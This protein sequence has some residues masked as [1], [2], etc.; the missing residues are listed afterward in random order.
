MLAFYNGNYDSG[1]IAY[2]KEANPWFT[3]LHVSAWTDNAN[4]WS[5]YHNTFLGSGSFR[6]NTW[7]PEAAILDIENRTHPSTV[8]LPAVINSSVSEWPR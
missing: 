3:Q 5:W 8:H 6:N 2:V 1:H 7:G 4:G